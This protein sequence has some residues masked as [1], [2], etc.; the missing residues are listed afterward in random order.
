MRCH[1][2]RCD[3]TICGNLQFDKNVIT[4]RYN[5]FTVVHTCAIKLHNMISTHVPV[6]VSGSPVL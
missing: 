5:G 3:N 2:C 4:T 6:T 1:I